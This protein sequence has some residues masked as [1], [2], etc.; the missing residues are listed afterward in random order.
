M[1]EKMFGGTIY[2][3][4]DTNADE[5]NKELDNAARDRKTKIDVDIGTK[6]NE[7]NKVIKQLED[8]DKK[9]NELDKKKRKTAQ[10]RSILTQLTVERRKLETAQRMLT[11]EISDYEKQMAEAQKQVAIE[12]Q[13]AANTKKIA[14]EKV[15]RSIEQQKNTTE[16]TVKAQEKLNKE[17]QKTLKLT[18]AKDDSGKIVP[19]TYTAVDGK[20]QITK[21]TEG[22]NLY[23][24]FPA[25]YITTYKTLNQIRSDSN[26]IA[27]QEALSQ[28]KIATQSS[29]T[30]AKVVQAEKKQKAAIEETTT[31]SQKKTNTINDNAI[32]SIS[33]YK[34][35]YKT[36]KEYVNLSKQL[37][38]T[39]LP[40]LDDIENLVWEHGVK[41]GS[42]DQVAKVIESRYKT[43]QNIKS[44]QKQ[45]LSIYNYID[46][47]GT[48][49]EKT[50]SNNTLKK[51]ENYLNGAIYDVFYSYGNSILEQFSQ[52]KIKSYVQKQT[53]A[54]SNLLS[55]NDKYQ[56][57]A[58]AFNAPIEEKMNEITSLIT[59]K[60]NTTDV[61]DILSKLKYQAKYVDRFTLSTEANRMGALLGLQTPYK[62]IEDNAKRIESYNELCD[63]YERLNKLNKNAFV[64]SKGSYDRVLTS[65][66]ELERQKLL[67]RFKASGIDRVWQYNSVDD[68]AKAMNLDAIDK[69]F[70]SMQKLQTLLGDLKQKYGNESFNNIFGET[71]SSIG[72]LNTSTADKMYNALI[73]KE[74]EYTKQQEIEAQKRVKIGKEMQKVNVYYNSISEQISNTTEGSKLYGDIL[75]K[76]SSGS[77]DA[78]SA[79]EQLNAA[80][81][82][83]NLLLKNQPSPTPLN[84]EFLKGVDLKSLTE[85]IQLPKEAQT[86]LHNQIVDLAKIL[87]RATNPKVS[88]KDSLELWKSFDSQ[89]ENIVKTITDSG[90]YLMENPID[91]K[92]FVEF[93]NYLQQ[94]PIKYTDE[95][96][97]EFDNE[98]WKNI[99]NEF[100][101][102]RNR[103]ITKNADAKTV[104]QQWA[105][106]VNMFPDVIKAVD[107][108]G[109]SIVNEKDRL[110]RV[111]DAV[112]NARE[113]KKSTKNINAPLG[114]GD[115][116]IFYEK[117]M[118]ISSQITKN[119]DSTRQAEQ[120]NTQSVEETVTAKQEELAVTKQITDET[121]KQEKVQSKKTTSNTLED[122]RSVIP[123]DVEQILERDINGALK[124]LSTARNNETVL[125][126][127]KGV[128]DGSDLINQAQ[129]MVNRI[130]QQSN[131]TLESFSVKDNIIYTKMVNDEL[132]VTVDQMYKL[133]S[134]TEETGAAMLELA[135]TKFSQNV[136]ALNTSGFDLEEATRKAESIYQ[137]LESRLKGQPYNGLK[138]LKTAMGS[139]VDEESFI[140]FNRQADL[141]SKEISAL[142]SRASNGMN[143]FEAMDKKM[144]K[145]SKV[146]EHLRNQVES[147]RH[148]SGAVE[149]NN[150][151]DQMEAASKNYFIAKKN[152]SEDAYT[153]Y[154]QYKKAAEA[155]AS[156]KTIVED[157]KRYIESELS[158]IKKLEDLNNQMKNAS[159]DCDRL[160]SQLSRLGRNLP[161]VEQ[162]KAS[163]TEA[164]AAIAEF[165]NAMTLAEKQAAANKYNTAKKDFNTYY[166]SAKEEQKVIDVV[167]KDD[168][169]I[170]DLNKKMET[171]S[172]KADIMQSRLSRLGDVKG[173]DK[174]A[175]AIDKARAAIEK[176]NQA[177]SLTDKQS[178]SKSF[179]NATKEF[180]TYYKAAQ[181]AQKA[182]KEI[183]DAWKNQ[184][185]NNY[186]YNN[187]KTVQDQSTLNSMGDWYKQEEAKAQSFNANIKNTYNDLISTLK[188]IN[189]LSSKINDLS[190]KD[191]GSGFYNKSLESL[192]SQKSNLI[193][194]MR[195][196]TAE[197]N[198]SFNIQPN[199]D[200]VVNFF[201]A[202]IKL[203]DVAR[204]RA[205]LTSAEIEK[206]DSLLLQSDRISYDFAS[207]VS[208]KVQPTFDKLISLQQLINNGSINNSDY[209]KGIETISNE[210]SSRM[211]NFKK[212]QD[213]ASAMDVI[214]FSDS[215]SKD[216]DSIHKLT[217]AESQYFA[218]YKKVTK[219]VDNVSNFKNIDSSNTKLEER[220]KSLTEFAQSFAQN[221]ANII[222][223]KQTAEGIT[224]LDFSYF[225]EGTNSVRKYTAAIGTLSD[226]IRLLETTVGPKTVKQ[227][228]DQQL[229]KMSA[230]LETL[231]LSN[232]D[233]NTK[234]AHSSVT[235]LIRLMNELQVAMSDGK[236]EEIERL[237]REAKMAT[238]QV[239]KLYNESIKLQSALNDG[240]AKRL[241]KFIP[242]NN[243]SAYDQL[244]RAVQNYA[245]S[246]D[247]VA[248]KVGKFHER[249][250][251]LDYTLTHGNGQVEHYT[252]SIN[253]LGK[254]IT[255]E[256]QGVTKLKSGWQDFSSILSRSA[257]QMTM[258][259]AGYNI[260]TQAIHFV[261]QGVTYIKEIDSA[262]VE[263]KK[264]TD[265][266]EASYAQFLNTASQDAS[267]I[268]ATTSD[269]VSAAANFARLGYSMKE[270]GDMGKSALVYKN[271]GDGLDS[272]EQATNSIIST[273]KAFGIQ[274]NDTMSIVDKFN[275]VGN[276][277]AI[278]SV[279]I[280]DALERSAS[281]LNEGGNTLDESIG[282][283]TAAN[284]V[285]QDPDVVGTALKTVALRMRGVKTELEDAGLETEG[286]AQTTSELQ[287]K[288]LALTKGKVDI[289]LNSDEF[290][291]TYEMLK[292]MS[293][294]WDD[295]TD[296]DRAAALELIAGKRQANIVASLISNFQTA[297]DA[298]KSAADSTGSA[299]TENEK[300]LDG[301][302]GKTKLLT[303]SLQNMWNNSLNSEGVKM[304][305]DIA[306]AIAKA[307]DKIGL[308]KTAIMAIVGIIAAR[309]NSFGKFFSFKNA[310]EA[311]K[312]ATRA[313]GANYDG[314]FSFTKG[315]KAGISEAFSQVSRNLDGWG[316][317]FNFKEIGSGFKNIGKE[318]KTAFTAASGIG[319]GD[320]FKQIKSGSGSSLKGFASQ[321][322][323]ATSQLSGFK[324]VSA[325]LK[326]VSNSATGAQVK[327]AA[328]TKMVGVA[329]IGAEV[330]VTALNMALT[331]GIGM[332]VSAAITGL[333]NLVHTQKNAAESAKEAAQESREAYE[334]EKS[335][336]Q[337]LTDSI[338][339][340]K[341]LRSQKLQTAQVRGEISSV[342]SE[343]TSL[344]GAQAAN[345]D[346]VNGNLDKE[347][348]KLNQIAGAQAKT[349]Q[350]KAKQSYND[351][352][353][354]VNK[355]IGE[356]S[357]LLF[358][359][360]ASVSSRD[361]GAEKFFQ[362]KGYLN[363]VSGGFFGNKTF[364]SDTLDKSGKELKTAVDKA[365]YLK[366]M[367]DEMEAG[368]DD[369]GDSEVYAG[370]VEQY[371]AYTE[372]IEARQQA[373]KSLLES[374]TSDFYYNNKELENQAVYS[375]ESLQKYRN[376]MV[377]ELSNNTEIKMALKNGDISMPEIYS[378]VDNFIASTEDFTA[379]YGAWKKDFQNKLTEDQKDFAKTFM[380][381]KNE[382]K[383]IQSWFDK[384][385]EEDQKLVYDIAVEFDDE[386]ASWSLDNWKTELESMQE[387]MEF[388]VDI[389]LESETNSIEGLNTAIKESMTA[390]GLTETSMKNL[391]G[392]Y[393]ELTTQGYNLSSMFE[394]TA[395]GIHLNKR[396]VGELEEAYTKQQ[397]QKIDKSLDALKG[398]Y[399]D[400]TNQINNCSD[401]SDKA[402]LMAE[403]ADIVSQINQIATL[404]AQLDGLT[405]SY[406][407][408]QDAESAG[409]ERDMYE[410]VISGFKTMDDEISRGWLD[411]SSI[412]F[413]E[414]L[415][416]KTDLATK[417]TK[418]LKKVYDGLD[419]NIKNTSY[420]VRDFF[421][422]DSDG[423]STNQ[424]VYNF[425]EAINSLE[426]SSVKSGIEDKKGNK[427]A[428]KDIKGIENLVKKD[429]NGNVVSFDF[430]IVGGDEAIAEAM[431]ISE[432]L[433]QI[434]LRA[435]DDAGFVVNLEGSY[436][437]LADLQEDAEAA[438][439]KL[440][441][442]SKTNSE[443]REAGGNYDFDFNTSSVTTIKDELTKAKDI[444]KTFKDDEG[445]IDVKAE[446]AKEAMTIVSTLQA[447]LDSLTAEKYGIGLTVEDEKY[448]KP[449]EYLQAYGHN[450]ATLN[451]LE[452][453]PNVNTKE[454]ADTKEKLNETV[455]AFNE[456]PDDVKIDIG[457]KDKN[458]SALQDAESIKKKIEAGKVTIP[459]T[460]DMQTK[461]S[462]D[463]EDLK[464]IALLNSGLLT[465]EQEE[466]I[467]ADLLVDINLEVGDVNTDKVEEGAKDATEDAGQKGAKKG[468]NKLKTWWQEYKKSNEVKQEKQRISDLKSQYRNAASDF[469]NGSGSAKETKRLIEEVRK[470]E[471]DLYNSQLNPIGDGLTAEKKKAI[472]D[473]AVEY[474]TTD[475]KSFSD[476]QSEIKSIEDKDVKIQVIAELAEAGAFDKLLEDL[477]D[478]KKQVIIQAL[479]EGTENVGLLNTFVAD[480]PEEKRVE[481]VALL[482]Q[483]GA[484]DNLLSTLDESDKKIVIDALVNGES[485]VD[486]LKTIIDELPEEKRTEVIAALAESGNFDSL[487]SSLNDEDRQVVID[488]LVTGQ[489]DVEQLNTIIDTLPDSVKSNVQ[490]LVKYTLG[491]Q[492]P[493][494]DKGA[495]VDY[496]KT[497]QE[498]PSNEGALVNY[499]KGNQ[500]L[501]D[502]KDTYVNYLRGSQEQPQ[503]LVAWVS[504]RL[505]GKD[506]LNG[507]AHAKG[508]AWA[509]GTALKQ[510]DWRTKKDEVA[511]TGELG[512]ELV[513]TGN[514]WYTVGDNGAEFAKIPRGSI[515]FNHK[516]TEEIFKNGYI[517]SRG[518]IAKANGTAHVK[519]TAWAEGTAYYGS[520]GSGGGLGPVGGNSTKKT[521][522]KTTTKK[523]TNTTKKKSTT[524]K[525]SSNK[526][527]TK[528]STNDFK[529]VFD[530]FEVRI[531]EI[532]EDLDLM[533]AKLENAASLEYKNSILNDMI[534]INKNELTTLEKGY[535]LYNSYANKL[536]KKIPKKY[537]TEA[538]NGKIAIE[539][540]KGKTDEKTLE[541][542]KNYREWAQKA[543][544]VKKQIQ[545]IKKEIADLAKQ[546]FD[547]IA[548]RY[549]DK[550]EVFDNYKQEKVQ[551]Y[552]D[553]REESGYVV[554]PVSY[555]KLI[556]EEKDKKSKLLEER[557]KLQASLDSAVKTGKIKKYSDEWYE[558]VQ[559][560]QDTDL[561]IDECT[562]S[563]EEFQNA[564]N[565][566]NWENFE[567]LLS[568]FE[569]F[570]DELNG[571]I[572][573]A[574]A[575]GEPVVTPD[576]ES[577]WSADEVQWSD[578]GILQLG[579]HAQ[580]MTN[581]QNTAEEYGKQID[582]LNQ[583]R[584]DE[585]I[586]VS[587]YNEKMA[588][589]K[590]G[591]YDAIQTYYDER[592][593]IIELNETRVDAIKEG[594]EK[595][596]DAYEELIDKKKEELD[597]EKDL[598]DFQKSVREQQKDIATLE[599]KL[600]ALSG[601]NS[602]SAMAKRRKLEAEL[603]EAR[604]N[605][606]DTYYDRSITN[607]QDLLDKSLE[608]KQKE[609]D[610][611]I[612]RL[613]KTLENTEQIV[614]DSF[615]VILANAGTVYD[616][617][618]KYT[619]EY[620]LHLSKTLTDAWSSGQPAIDQYTGSF[621]DAVSNSSATEQGLSNIETDEQSRIDNADTYAG[622]YN[623][624]LD[625]KNDDITEEKQIKVGGKIKAGKNTRIYK[626]TNSKNTAPNTKKSYSQKYAKDPKYKVLGFSSGGSYV[627]VRW[628]KD[629][630][631]PVRWFKVSQVHALAKGTKKLNKS[632]LVNIDEL[633]EEL[634]ISAKNGRLSYLEK[635]SGVIPADL[636]S[637]LMEWGKLDPTSI[638]EQ[639]KPSIIPNPEVKATEINLN[640][641]YGDMLKI[642][643][644]DGNN[645]EEIAKIVAKQFEK[646][647][648]DLNN[649]LRKYVR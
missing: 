445:N 421:T 99:V 584:K 163:L 298:A 558:M 526:N 462:G 494:S 250:N 338:A 348:E 46:D 132:K 485:D 238:S 545:E 393:S 344:V 160:D 353:K 450:M 512:Q 200:R 637:N 292:E 29:D 50:L 358:D 517:N 195:N 32:K 375:T 289:Q 376:K 591:Q 7:L 311:A 113:I 527:K 176:F 549:S 299:L 59:S 131:L 415:T 210:M 177:K 567:R 379:Y 224:K 143:A 402:S 530:W 360:Y 197:I 262:M 593:A 614:K 519:G 216:I 244:N 528:K 53:D 453:N 226:D 630:K 268:G 203:F 339:K 343:I 135:S 214:G 283:I 354:A 440:K 439:D 365:E 500:G 426:S 204:E 531:E 69:G 245:S 607:Q 290:K 72:T 458:G 117:L 645:P 198:K 620:G 16:Q 43:V 389:N 463:V 133:R 228:A 455:Q 295:M 194:E 9:Q 267:K 564:I 363:V 617:L 578:E 508:T 390:S 230:M 314:G 254:I 48:K 183:N 647:T 82:K 569:A 274:S 470:A 405:S 513:V 209:V 615:D 532:N 261:R 516:Q 506:Q 83:N 319:I 459:T 66:E 55:E 259:Y 258:I 1:A 307:V 386:A 427:I 398:K 342:Q 403:R 331:M 88:E 57:D 399:N 237:T 257:K 74:Q 535:K 101:K 152:G 86:K 644:F 28:T 600:A 246:L 368:Y 8:I 555:D 473:V 380:K 572:D 452:I 579:L 170:D 251:K 589:L 134:A 366:S 36:L 623:S 23:D 537:R 17:I 499:T 172:T 466:A 112:R 492:E 540:F 54:F 525:R 265:E 73:A 227:N 539:T 313:A 464:K 191:G 447:K 635:G 618:M 125:F 538:K 477:P 409:N 31:A 588:E 21:G 410:N 511:L 520:S 165:N 583:L 189:T 434:M 622:N 253:Q 373:A 168:A 401:A 151:V 361:K 234:T 350:E 148:V 273:M 581:A 577:G 608:T 154:D 574:S 397:K 175:S 285:I 563:V 423:N 37:K 566:L 127:L 594:I 587:E 14:T 359:G 107:E 570:Q 419:K 429:K 542:I 239:Q 334:T 534:K 79:I 518:R 126:N 406:K 441:E 76:V 383:D 63:V 502:P 325:A 207:K 649:S 136:K 476:L 162:A 646:H 392:R 496:T 47:D 524:K 599:R 106:L 592:D 486:Q 456:L 58:Q 103:I 638:I 370:L 624:S 469:I 155:Y 412:E 510:G 498:A 56:K 2:F 141:A 305:L 480:L 140:A 60:G 595:E 435:A 381:G 556:E 374:T 286:M 562:M 551:G 157:N 416:G 546:K 225:D 284:S 279:G 138:S 308:F 634:V 190:L 84:S 413:L 478:G 215:I 114:S 71:I 96:K 231:K 3:D 181:E 557:K 27:E 605:L 22:W 560:I 302:E 318:M 121:K 173:I 220:K 272:V 287:K 497:G 92:P 430:G 352:N 460:L 242:D 474:D 639:N 260:Y 229:G 167:V 67:A 471:K 336:Q 282:L 561:A 65:N 241:E 431:G 356:D 174:A 483:S 10:D 78:S 164:R 636:T 124:Q 182:Q 44:S 479:T 110:T 64:Y 119:I 472:V 641:Q 536:Y 391:Q 590:K 185:Q 221:K 264:V 94:S 263:L 396:A 490:A 169:S 122:D 38:S 388:S 97:K 565:E 166:A 482:A 346:L 256:N 648:K 626:S 488:A 580:A 448:Q 288:L 68:V 449:L 109:N 252:A 70:E 621:K 394:E 509:G 619:D 326:A 609:S 5:A 291:S 186:K 146:V 571:L 52:K 4:V 547:N 554:S 61:D 433:V 436:K 487:L 100:G 333:M 523:K 559:T 541:K 180:N 552:I 611:E 372:L 309:N 213:G 310:P 81:E 95:Y 408:W 115:E 335:N 301:I 142:S 340:Y 232:F 522:S 171:A 62:D 39:T 640:I 322:K 235:N 144:Q 281:A 328:A 414:L 42:L 51:A 330:A 304:F 428:F 515:V 643:N 193:G 104:D 20:Y 324:K 255:S 296:I 266:T 351:A 341:E 153:Y 276:N 306:N 26:L 13:E 161:G 139:I 404:G 613:E 544:D 575:V 384:L 145:S 320:F 432:E 438:N 147:L 211:E 586:S 218:N 178:A 35:L 297:E 196:I 507:T 385:S 34:E 548:D 627:K 355:A 642:N 550:I 444:L 11:N 457:L 495:G 188:Q 576:T 111:L 481:V 208:S 610:K 349:T 596:L 616:T 521:T 418:E 371:N 150:F 468:S 41:S 321:I 40:A 503:N 15:T 367:I 275:E 80:L 33:S 582:E 212:Y 277:F 598:Y 280:G 98:T 420:S 102:S 249:Q 49:S 378:Y 604:Q 345:L 317:I 489:G 443:L 90:T 233:I 437:Q 247:G 137:K 179:E 6:R 240:S 303:N 315:L 75:S 222:D 417:S 300:V 553:R 442:L 347:L 491:S 514:R 91:K 454:I 422:V 201:N 411:D 475:G 364:V 451:Q 501:P 601:D 192:Q 205:A 400:L 108:N 128:V 316:K 446:G 602:A 407:A 269:Y 628:Y 395:N 30:A 424:G 89:L 505:F 625:N 202:V 223:F 159:I 293:A 504:Y 606:E 585:K 129:N 199:E 156:Q 123:V 19:Q 529:E 24:D 633:G 120:K 248:L 219:D 382:S 323:Q 278:T 369:Y 597:A 484:Y 236:P 632:G 357:F 77:L 149:L 243:V 158:G 184:F 206:F 87:E 130:A 493:P 25:G 377:E 12:A 573:I 270:A 467:K 116:D 612:E 387:T 425:L 312:A 45:G 118:E 271:V 533:A 85:G 465:K 329:A 105:E 93:L 332:A 362:D 629:K 603:A 18:K 461:M 543:A 187:G 294:V 327:Q 337:T 217:Q 568:R 631:A